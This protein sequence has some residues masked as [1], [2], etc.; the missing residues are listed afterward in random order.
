MNVKNRSKQAVANNEDVSD[1]SGGETTARAPAEIAEN[2]SNG[3][4]KGHSNDSKGDTTAS[5][6]TNNSSLSRSTTNA[7]FGNDAK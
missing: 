5:S 2:D 4:G 3:K 7:S 6:L 1:S